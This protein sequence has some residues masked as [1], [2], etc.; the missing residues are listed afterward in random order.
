[1]KPPLILQPHFSE[2]LASSPVATTSAGLVP[3][4]PV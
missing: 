1:V 3:S 4:T 2:S